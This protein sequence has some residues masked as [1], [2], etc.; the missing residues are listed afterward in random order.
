MQKLKD[1]VSEDGNYTI[2]VTWEMYGTVTIVGCNNLEEALDVAERYKDD[3]PLPTDGDY[4]DDSFGLE[5]DYIIDAQSFP[6][7]D[8]YFKNPNKK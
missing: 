4:I 2:P 6:R 1:Y 3:L 7:Y 8:A 5:T